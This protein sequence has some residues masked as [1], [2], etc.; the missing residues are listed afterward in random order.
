MILEGKLTR[1]LRV[2]KLG[3][4]YTRVSVCYKNKTVDNILAFIDTGADLSIIGTS[5]VKDL[6]IEEIIYERTWIAS[7]GD[8]RLSPIVEVGIRAEDDDE[9]I[10]LDE[11]IM[12]D[13][14]LDDEND[15][16]VILG[17]D[18]LQRGKKTLVFDD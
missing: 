9:F 5:I 8:R 18:Y 4:K 6:E 17:L 13:A 10:E 11:V 1:S 2:D 7:D 16:E 14:P 3:R 12:D 15:E